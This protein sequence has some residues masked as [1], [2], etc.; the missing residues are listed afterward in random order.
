MTD[1][2]HNT[3]RLSMNDKL[4]LLG[5]VLSALLTLGIP[6]ITSL[7][8]MWKQMAVFEVQLNHT[9]NIMMEVKSDVRTLTNEY[10]QEQKKYGNPRS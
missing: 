10:R 8:M 2:E 1:N 7:L 6:I 4:K 5:I 3:V 9:N